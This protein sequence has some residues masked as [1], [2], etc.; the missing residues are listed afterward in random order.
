MAGLPAGHGSS[1]STSC[2]LL[3]QGCGKQ[4]QGFMSHFQ[5]SSSW[6]EISCPKC[7]LSRCLIPGRLQQSWV[8]GDALDSAQPGGDSKSF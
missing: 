2:L 7:L 5:A 8:Q 6:K 4:Q 1:G 3:G